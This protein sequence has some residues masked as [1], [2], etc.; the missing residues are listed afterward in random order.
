MAKTVKV[1]YSLSLSWEQG[2]LAGGV[3]V[4]TDNK[5]VELKENLGESNNHLVYQYH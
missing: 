5:E 2:E 1:G 4:A 3:A